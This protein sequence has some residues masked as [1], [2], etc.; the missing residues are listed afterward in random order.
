MEFV[1]AAI[2][3]DLAKREQKDSLAAAMPL[4]DLCGDGCESRLSVAKK[5][6]SSEM[7]DQLMWPYVST[8]PVYQSSHPV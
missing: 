3:L 2:R 5:P 8:Y 1:A 7:R 4:G 6:K